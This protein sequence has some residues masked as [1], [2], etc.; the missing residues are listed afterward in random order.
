M[1]TLTQLLSG[2]KRDSSVW[3]YFVYDEHSNK[4]RCTV[5]NAKGEECGFQMAGKR[6][7]N[8]KVHMK[9]RHEAAYS[10]LQKSEMERDSKTTITSQKRKPDQTHEGSYSKSLSL[11]CRFMQC[12]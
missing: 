12:N 4:S 7:S 8:L 10:Q 9:A 5:L 1:T 11:G 2:R 6:T 3:E